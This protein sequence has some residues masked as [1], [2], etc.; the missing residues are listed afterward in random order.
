MS[1]IRCKNFHDSK[2]ARARQRSVLKSVFI[3]EAHLPLIRTTLSSGHFFHLVY[4]SNLIREINSKK[5][6]ET[7]D[8]RCTIP[9]ERVSLRH[10][11]HETIGH[12]TKFNTSQMRSS[13][14]CSSASSFSVS[15]RIIR[16]RLP[17]ISAECCACELSHLLRFQCRK[18]SIAETLIRNLHIHK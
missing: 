7:D 17:E 15:T 11:I 9:A 3:F 5:V 4:N 14:E 10:I 2:L 12:N 6:R 18:A 1:V 8:R 13:S 16:E